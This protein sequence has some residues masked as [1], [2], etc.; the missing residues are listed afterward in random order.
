MAAA[1][2]HV[3]IAETLLL[4][5]AK[6]IRNH[7]EVFDIDCEDSQTLT[8]LMKASIKGHLEIVKM[9]LKFG[10]NPRKKNKRSESS[11]ALACMQ[12]NAAIVERLI[13]AKAD[14]NE[15]DVRKRTPLLK[16]ARHN[17]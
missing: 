3:E 6:M 15:T 1:N 9:L 7:S 10:A 4:H 16:C 11:L 2:G 13:I 12:E 17:A 8:P 5:W 14:V